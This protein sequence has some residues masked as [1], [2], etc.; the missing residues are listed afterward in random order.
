MNLS[1]IPTPVYP[2]DTPEGWQRVGAFYRRSDGFLLRE[3]PGNDPPRNLIGKGYIELFVVAPGDWLLLDKH[4]DGYDLGD[5]ACGA[6]ES[7]ACVGYAR[8]TRALA[9]GKAGD[10]ERL[11]N[12][13]TFWM[14][15]VNQAVP[16][17][18]VP[19]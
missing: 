15:A 18:R 11:P 9:K 16:L 7:S 1:A 3:F 8:R 17:P 2:D 19:V 10:P 5:S 6:G 12:D 4:F 13:F 14:N